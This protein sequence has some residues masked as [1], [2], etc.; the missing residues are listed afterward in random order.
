MK[1][2]RFSLAAAIAATG[3]L[4]P[5]GAVSST[6]PQ[7]DRTITGSITEL[8]AFEHSD[9]IRPGMLSRTR[10]TERLIVPD[11]L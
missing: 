9:L 1:S 7:L 8:V 5:V 4:L 10:R 2:F 3:L 6:E 11:A